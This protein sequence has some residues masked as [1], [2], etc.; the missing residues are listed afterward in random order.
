M[1]LLQCHKAIPANLLQLAVRVILSRSLLLVEFLHVKQI[2]WF[3]PR[4][5]GSVICQTKCFLRLA[6]C[7]HQVSV[8]CK[9]LFTKCKKAFHCNLKGGGANKILTLY[10]C[11]F[12]HL[13]EFLTHTVL[14]PDTVQS[15]TLETTRRF[16]S[17]MWQQKKPTLFW[18]YDTEEP[19]NKT[20][21]KYLK[22]ERLSKLR[23]SLVKRILQQ[24]SLTRN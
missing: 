6:M 24:Q 20:F 1:S 4:G 21:T 2:Q 15:Q 19:K 12:G 14:Y 10:Y 7:I 3:L 5:H 23:E 16:G 9:S 13:T 8:T 18:S 22:C 17:K 11:T